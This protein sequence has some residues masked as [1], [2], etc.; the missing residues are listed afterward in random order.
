MQR[1]ALKYYSLLIVSYQCSSSCDV[2]SLA[3]PT[4][5]IAA[6]PESVNILGAMANDVR[7]PDKLID[8]YHDTIEGSH[9]WLAPILPDIVSPTYNDYMIRLF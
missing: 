9:M 8:G 2:L 7:T 5:D 3:P 1:M 4:T 6:Y